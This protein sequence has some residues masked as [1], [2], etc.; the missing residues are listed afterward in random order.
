VSYY[1]PISYT[2]TSAEEGWLL[3]AV[4][5]RKLHIS[6]RL[7]SRLKL[8][9]Q[10]ITV[11][12]VRS[13][14]SVTV[15]PGDL[16]EVRMEEEQSEDI[17]PQ[18]MPLDILFEDD[19]LLILNKPPGVIVHPTHGHYTNTLANGVVH[20]GLEQGKKI[21]FR[22]VHRLDQ[23]TSGVLAIAKNPYAHQHISEQM[24]AG[25]VLKEYTAYVF[26]QLQP[27]S[28]TV[29]E[30][31]DRDTEEPHI[32]VVRADGY[33]A[34]THYEASEIYSNAT[35]VRITLET[36]RTHQIRV[37]MKHLSHPLIGDKLYTLPLYTAAESECSTLHR[38]FAITRH[39]LHAALLAF[40]HPIT[41]EWIR[42]A[43]PQPEDLIELEQQLQKDGV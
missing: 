8:T 25:T 24:I 34:V 6:R 10:G 33:P 9:E 42:I 30:P 3:R 7:L 28:G 18:P 41:G 15:K 16:V 5:Q 14:I 12:G 43:A 1:E 26:G 2:V 31:I 4:L 23:E 19:Q 38:P 29:N 11:N 27:T 22:P 35:R 32:R 37:H 40:A 13:Y 39:A 20:Y 17:L 36:G 21:R